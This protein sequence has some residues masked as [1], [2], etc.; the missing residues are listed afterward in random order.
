[1]PLTDTQIK[2]LKP[3]PRPIKHSDGGGLHI[4][5]SPN[6]GKLWRLSYRYD[7]K[8]KTLALGA[9][10]VVSLSDA[11]AQRNDAKKLLAS[12]VDP[13]WQR[14]VDKATR[15]ALTE[16]TFDA[17]ADDF[18]AKAERE[19]KSDAT[20]TKKRWLIGIARAEFGQRPIAG[21][22]AADVLVPLRKVEGQGN[23]E[24]ARRLRAGEARPVGRWRVASS[25]CCRARAGLCWPAT[26]TTPPSAMT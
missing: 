24:T 14:K 19:G 25:P 20:L 6:G 2:A 3:A 22:S 13:S 5:V 11:R 15:Q 4:L 26:A 10:P 18:L 8:Q 21:I 1:M 17:V 9:Y 7:G 12:G 16:N 23:Y